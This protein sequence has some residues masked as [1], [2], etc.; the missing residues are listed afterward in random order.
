MNRTL[1]LPACIALLL[2]GL[3]STLLPLDAVAA[4]PR[5]RV[6]RQ[7][8]LPRFSYPLPASPSR[9]V[10][11]DAATFA[12]FAAK[13]RA[14][15]DRV[16]A[17]YDIEDRST[18]RTILAAKLDLQ[19]L[20]GDDAGGLQTADAL[21]AL[22]DKPASRLLSALTAR[23]RLQAAL[24]AGSASGPAYDRRFASATRRSSRRCRGLSPRTASRAATAT[25]A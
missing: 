19:E 8:D 15:I 21:G 9:F 7:T 23:A 22:E 2:A 4:N 3:L 24:D 16:L 18:L 25:R 12:A 1:K 11:S 20:A 14:D 13:V 10:E 17:D 5:T 6:T